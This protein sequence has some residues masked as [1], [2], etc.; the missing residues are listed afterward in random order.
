ML[1]CYLYYY[2]YAYMQAF[3]DVIGNIKEIKE[4]PVKYT[5]QFLKG[6]LKPSTGNVNSYKC[7]CDKRVHQFDFLS[8]H[9][10]F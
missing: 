6:K 9:V 10:S 1:A 4:G 2:I 8:F 7:S 3:Y 5:L